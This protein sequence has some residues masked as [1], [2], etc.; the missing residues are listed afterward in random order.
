MPP[1]VLPPEPAD[2]EPPTP[3]KS[4]VLP[5]LLTLPPPEPP[6]LAEDAA[7]PA[8]PALAVALAPPAFPPVPPD[9]PELDAPQPSTRTSRLQMGSTATQAHVIFMKHL[10]FSHT[11]RGPG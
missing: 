8:P 6:G 10:G 11:E 5:P 2:V 3:V 4:P 1:V 9:E 7:P